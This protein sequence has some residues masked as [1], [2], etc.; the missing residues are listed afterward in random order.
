VQRKFNGGK[1]PFSTNDAGTINWTSI[2][3]K[4]NLNPYLIPSKKINSKMNHR[5]IN[6]NLYVEH[7]CNSGTTLWN[8]GEEGKEKRMT[9]HQY[10]NTY[11]CA[12]RGSNDMY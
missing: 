6:T 1:I 12:G 3:K 9:Q 7:V 5:S 8:L 2:Y 10:G 11:I 4:W